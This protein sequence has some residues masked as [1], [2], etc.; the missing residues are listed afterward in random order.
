MK[1]HSIPRGFRPFT[2]DI[3]NANSAADVWQA[4]EPLVAQNEPAPYPIDSL[5]DPIRHAVEEVQAFVQAPIEMVAASALTALS[6]AGQQVADVRR[7]NTLCGPL[8]LFF[9]SV[10]ESG[11]RKS[12]ID[13]YF[14]NAIREYERGS[15]RRRSPILRTTRQSWQRGR[16]SERRPA[17]S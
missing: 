9:L 10:A 7:A 2:V 17:A 5:P 6:I 12:T 16:P 4:P 11:E 3:G 1:P 13:G 8:S 14:V 15:A